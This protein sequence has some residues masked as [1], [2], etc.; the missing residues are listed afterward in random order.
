MKTMRI[1]IIRVVTF[2]DETILNA[3]GHVIERAF[4]YFN[5]LSRCIPDQRKGIYNQATLRVATPKV[6][7]LGLQLQSEGV[8]ALI[9]SCAEDPGVEK[10]RRC[11]EIPVIGAGSAAA[12]LALT[13]GSRVGALNLTTRTPNAIMKVLGKHF[14]AEAKPRNITTTLDLLKDKMKSEVLRAAAQLRNTGVDVV[15][16]GCT[17]YTTMGVASEIQTELK[18]P[19]IDPILAAGLAAFYA[20]QLP[21]IA[22]SHGDSGIFH[23]GE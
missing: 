22:R 10:L 14:T 18:V 5:T 16:L 17:G 9:V 3:H 21:R 15:V 1:G 20:T 7:R 13:L 23:S 2:D 19:V 8:E 6:V 11:V 12:G 4:P